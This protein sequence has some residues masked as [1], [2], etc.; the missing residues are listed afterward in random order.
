MNARALLLILLAAPLGAQ[1]LADRVR[2]FD[3]S[4]QV[5]YPSRP[6]ACGDGRNYIGNVMGG[7]MGNVADRRDRACVHGP[8]RVLVSLSGHQ[9]IGLRAAVGMAGWNEVPT[10]ETTAGEAA[11]F[12]G[13]LVLH[14]NSRIANDAILPLML[15]DGADPWPTLLRA[16]RDET[17]SLSI[18]RGA[19]TWLAIGVNA[20]LGL[21]RED[22]QSDDDEV[23]KQAVFALSQRPKTESVPELIEIARTSKSRVARREAIFWLGQT[24]DT[25]AADLYAELLGLR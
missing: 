6:D 18:R 4:V 5:I 1:S 3:R 9:I 10:L 13:D 2:A 21:T 22:D 17:R 16:A 14:D 24:G 12:F 7:V 19:M 23:K 25:R 8:A 15:A 11:A 20:K